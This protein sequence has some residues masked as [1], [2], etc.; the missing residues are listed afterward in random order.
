M[1][2]GEPKDNWYG[3]YCH[4]SFYRQTHAPTVCDFNL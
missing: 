1:L 4:C 3:Q 2:L